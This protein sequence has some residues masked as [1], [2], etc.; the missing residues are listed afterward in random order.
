MSAPEPKRIEVEKHDKAMAA[1]PQAAAELAWH[2]PHEAPFELTGFP[3]FG[4]DRIYRRLPVKPPEPIREP[5]DNLA[6]CTAGGQ[7]RFRTDSRRVAVR[8]KLRAPAGMVHMPATGQCGFDAYFDSPSG[9]VYGNT[10][11]YPIREDRYELEL[12]ALPDR[13]ERAFTLYFPLYQ[14]V[15]ELRVGLDPD[16]TLAPPPAWAR[17]GK[18]VVY[19]TSITQGGCACRPGMAWTNILSRRLNLEFVNL[20]FSGNGR[21]E[22]ELARL[23]TQIERPRL[24]VLDYEANSNLEGLKATLEPFIGILR[25]HAPTLPI[26]VISRF[27]NG[28]EVYDAQARANRQ[29]TREYQADV[30]RQCAARGDKQIHFLDG[31]NLLGPSGAE[32]TVDLVHPT[33][34]GFWQI[35]NGLEPVIGN[36]AQ[37]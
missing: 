14:G 29:A 21:G 19:G 26:L 9:P 28:R 23:I 31:S 24:Y 17:E 12:L 20:G 1:G 22:P 18:V 32:G 8:V 6:W 33:D 4:Q 37:A 7:V 35:A 27:A 2:V 25:A 10:T 3:W 5:V 15:E 16:A 36:L 11:K 13:Q 30:V 34:L